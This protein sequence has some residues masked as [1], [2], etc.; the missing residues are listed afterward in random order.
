VESINDI[1][2]YVDKSTMILII[3]NNAKSLLN[4]L[5]NSI[6]NKCA[7]IKYEYNKTK[8]LIEK[9][10]KHK[11]KII[12]IDLDLNKIQFTSSNNPKKLNSEFIILKSIILGNKSKILFK[13]DL[14]TYKEYVDF[15]NLRNYII[16]YDTF[17]LII[18]IDKTDI[19]ILESI[20][21]SRRYLETFSIEQLIR[22]VK[23]KQIQDRLKKYENNL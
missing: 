6:Y 10:Q 22:K 17:D 2:E 23:L 9:V 15:K 19:K 14:S 20:N 3:N 18:L 16:A 1:Q 4:S 7:L 11:E 12:K 5:V 13:T 21:Y 8:G